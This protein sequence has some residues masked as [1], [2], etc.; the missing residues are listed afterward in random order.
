MADLEAKMK[1]IKVILGTVFFLLIVF[2]GVHFVGSTP[3]SAINLQQIGQQYFLP[4]IFRKDII[5][6]SE[7]FDVDPTS[8][9]PWTP[10]NWDIAV[11]S[12]DVSTWNNLEP[13]DAAHGSDCSPH[14]AMHRITQYKD[15][16]FLCRNHLMTA[17]N[18]TGYGV[19]YLTP[20][21]MVD[22][23]DQEAVVRFD[24]STARSS[25]RDWVD[26]WITPYS[27]HL[28]LPLADFYPDL[29]G[30]PRRAIQ[31]EMANF[32]RK[33]TFGLNRIAAFKATGYTGTTWIG[34]EDFLTTSAT[35]R[36]TFEL[37]ISRTH[38][39]FGMPAYNFW[40]Y[41]KSI[42]TLDWSVGVVQFGHHSYNPRKDCNGCL[43]NT[44]HWDNISIRPAV[45]FTIVR[46]TQ[47]YSDAASGAKI[48][49]AAPAPAGANLQFAGIGKSLQ[50]SYDNGATWIKATPQAQE[51]YSEDSF[52]SYWMPIPTGT[53][54]VRFKGTKWWGGNWRV[55]DISAWSQVTP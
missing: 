31:V 6:F 41:N 22:F 32:N 38:I 29:S 37:R 7:T 46:A 5:T 15:S 18:A 54:T 51:R 47:R 14:P 12:R 4:S 50:V 33:T 55:K 49:L 3:A 40:W 43:P 48:T 28:Q 19:I 21:A 39:M 11:H 42:P 16:V 25:E 10:S 9:Q 24:L 8:P 20:N 52:W 36:D 53:T 34:Y 1:K 26:L 45:P 27:E 17:I 44:W 35:R 13:M 23:T 2:L 30:E